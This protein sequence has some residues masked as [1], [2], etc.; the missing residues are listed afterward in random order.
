LRFLIFLVACGFSTVDNNNINHDLAGADLAG[1][2]F[3]GVDFAAPPGSDMAGGCN[4]CNCGQ[5]ALLVAVESVNG[6]TSNDGRILQ[7]SL[8]ST[9]PISKCGKDLTVNK[10]LEKSPQ[11]LAWY[12]PDGILFGGET[13]L[14]LIDAAKDLYRWNYK[15]QRSDIPLAAF[16]LIKDGSQVVGAGF[17]TTNFGEMQTLQIIDPKNGMMLF[18]WDMTDANNSPIYLGGGIVGLTQS[19]LDPTHMFYMKMFVNQMPAADIAIPY[20]NMMVKGTPY[21][22]TKPSGTDL[23][24]ISVVKN[25]AGGLKRVAWLQHNTGNTLGDNIYYVNDD[26]TGPTQTGPLVCNNMACKTP[27]KSNDVAPDPTAA[28]RVFATCDSP[29]DNLGHVVRLDDSGACDVVLDGN[30]LPTLTY[31]SR[32]AI[33]EAR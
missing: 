24:R 13:T 8:S 9:G 33:A 14:Y 3:S 7:F 16:P 10:T 4:T 27:F 6:A 32:L 17:D 18:S 31:P 26:G 20:D 2:D 1:L 5:A 25:A 15:T 28:N 11:S 21:W 23:T 12:P 30:S 29:T 19:P 22:P